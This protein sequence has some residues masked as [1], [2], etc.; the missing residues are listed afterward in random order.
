MGAPG[1]MSA[2]L[3]LPTLPAPPGAFVSGP[4][5]TRDAALFTDLYEL[6]IA[7]W[8]FREGMHEPATFS[9]FVRKLPKVCAVAVEP[10]AG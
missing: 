1:S 5:V 3:D 2:S 8:Y 6:T 4:I 9:L 10:V 7:A